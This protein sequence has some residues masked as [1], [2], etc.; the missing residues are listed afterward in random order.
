[1]IEGSWIFDPQWPSHNQGVSWFKM[2]CQEC[3]P[4]TYAS[5]HPPPHRKEKALLQITKITFLSIQKN[6]LVKIIFF[7]RIKRGQERLNPK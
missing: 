3:R 6:K 2:P 7:R 4:D 5:L 1:M